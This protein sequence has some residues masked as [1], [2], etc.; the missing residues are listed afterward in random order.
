MCPRALAHF[1]RS[2]FS[3]ATPLR[4][5]TSGA[6]WKAHDAGRGGRLQRLRKAMLST[7]CGRT[8]LPSFTQCWMPS[9]THSRRR[10][11]QTSVVVATVL[12]RPPRDRR[13]SIL[14]TVGGM[15]YTASTSGPGPRR[16]HDAARSRRSATRGRR[17]WP[18]SL[19]RIHRTRACALA[20]AGD[21]GDDRELAARDADVD[22]LQVVLARV[23]DADRL[24]VDAARGRPPAPAHERPRRLGPSIGFAVVARAFGSGGAPPPARPTS[25]SPRSAPSSLALPPR[26]R[27][28]SARARA[29]ARSRAARGRCASARWP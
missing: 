27:P 29:S 12:L 26:R 7:L 5:T 14:A 16:L 20:R 21:A 13:C 17:R 15:P 10:K 25:S 18:P 1:A 24:V 8:G 9:F 4:A 23:D 28:H 6:S 3:A 2:V 11:C 22:R 19:N